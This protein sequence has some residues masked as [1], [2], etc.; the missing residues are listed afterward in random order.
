MILS[1]AY[2]GNIQ[3]YSKLI[4]GGTVIDVH[5]NYQKQS[6]RNRTEI[7]TAAGVTPLTIPVLIPSGEKIS[8]RDVKIDN[9]KRWQHRHWN[10]I[11]SAYANSPYFFHYGE[12]L[13]LFYKKTYD[14]LL[15]F[16]I[17][18]QETILKLL[19]I[20][21]GYTLGSEYLRDIPEAADFRNCISPKPRLQRED[22]DF[23]A[24]VYYQVFSDTVPFAENLSVIDLLMCEGPASSG[25]IRE[26]YAGYKQRC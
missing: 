13:S 2:L 23:K 9:S 20:E 11:A 22:A 12:Y 19:K 1:T 17:E 8:T 5:E 15:D 4:R 3:Y 16:N 10:A 21:A 6:Y 24:P 7:M 26:S 25:I 14:F 18:T